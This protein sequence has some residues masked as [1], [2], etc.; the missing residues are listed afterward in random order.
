MIFSVDYVLW[1]LIQND[2][3]Y[4]F[5]LKNQVC[6]DE[7]F[8]TLAIWDLLSKGRTRTGGFVLVML[9]VPEK[10]FY[11]FLWCFSAL[12]FILSHSSVWLPSKLCQQY[13]LIVF[14]NCDFV[15]STAFHIRRFVILW[16][17]AV[18][19]ATVLLVFVIVLHYHA[20]ICNLL[21]QLFQPFS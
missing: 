7:Q 16:L 13:V 3:F 11:L 6:R 12:C 9:L 5:I 15:N 19:Y 2:L 18:Q 1:E 17:L 10:L 21:K 8:S 14:L 20:T 4:F